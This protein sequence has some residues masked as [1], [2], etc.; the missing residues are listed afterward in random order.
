LQIKV[1]PLFAEVG[2]NMGVPTPPGILFLMDNRALV[3][4]F[5]ALLCLVVWSGALIYLDAPGLPFVN[6][7]FSSLRHRIVFAI[8]WRRKRLQRDFSAMLAILVDAGMPEPEA[9]AL[10]ADCTANNVFRE[11]AQRAVAALQ[12]GAKLTEAVQ[13]VD[14]A[15][16][17]R[18]R[19]SNALHA[20]K[21]FFTALAGW[22]ESLDA[23]AYQ[24][25]QA[26]AQVVTT[27]LVL[28]N[29]VLVGFIVV[30]VFS[31]LVSVINVG[32]LW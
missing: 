3:F 30:S 8:P 29:G 20:H 14:D 15:G 4:L 24:Q 32:L 1:F 22:S 12:Q 17:F 19:I 13:M 9:V 16:E 10:A 23:K 27:G 6:T 7:I 25:E 31:I 18:W 26:T 28:L 21:N 2:E 5:Q 11:R